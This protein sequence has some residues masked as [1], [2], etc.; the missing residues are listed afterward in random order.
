MDVGQW[1]GAGKSNVLCF[2]PLPKKF[3]VLLLFR[4]WRGNRWTVFALVKQS[5]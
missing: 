2:D 5:R 3:P 1:S 4:K